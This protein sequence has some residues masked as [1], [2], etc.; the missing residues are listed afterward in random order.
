M[1]IDFEEVRWRADRLDDFANGRGLPSGLQLRLTGGDAGPSD[2]ISY[3]ALTLRH[4]PDE[5]LLFVEQLDPGH[6]NDRPIAVTAVLGGAYFRDIGSAM[7]AAGGL[8]LQKLSATVETTPE[9][10]TEFAPDLTTSMLESA[11]LGLS[12]G[13]LD[14]V[15]RRAASD[16]AAALPDATGLLVVE[17]TSERGLGMIQIGMAGTK[18]GAEVVSFALSGATVG[19]G[20]TPK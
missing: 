10:M 9:L 14:R 7:M 11:I 12:F 17:L 8:N 16:F 2:A 13:Q 18:E 3:I 20:W 1:G 15:D 4:L 5:G 6:P 19:V